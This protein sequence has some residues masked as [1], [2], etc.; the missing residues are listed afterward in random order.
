MAA[1][2]F[3][4]SLSAICFITSVAAGKIASGSAVLLDWAMAML[5]AIDSD[6]A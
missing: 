1:V 5:P 3:S 6:Y 2:A 4:A